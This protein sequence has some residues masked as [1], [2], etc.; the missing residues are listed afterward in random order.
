MKSS[1]V[2]DGSYVLLILT[3][4]IVNLR[5]KHVYAMFHLFMT[6]ADGG[7]CLGGLGMSSTGIKAA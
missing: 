5:P 2:F 7:S 6:L 1:S 3:P 4:M